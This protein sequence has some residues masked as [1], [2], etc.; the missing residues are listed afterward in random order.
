MPCG[1]WRMALLALAWLQVLQAAFLQVLDPWHHAWWTVGFLLALALLPRLSRP[2]AWLGLGLF[3]L[4]LTFSSGRGEHLR[5][6]ALWAFVFD[7]RWLPPVKPRAG[8]LLL[9]FDGECM[10]CNRAIRFLA[11]EDRA[12]LLRFVK[13]Q[14]KRG[15]ALEAVAGQGSLKTMLVQEDGRVL[16]RS[17]AALRVARALGG[18]WRLLA[19]LGSVAPRPLADALYDFIAAHR[20]QWFGKAADS[21]ELPTPELLSRLVDGDA[22]VDET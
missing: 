8:K 21:C 20:Y 13:L 17:S 3:I 16:D 18:H 14:S 15:A 4:A 11:T 2:W 22:E 7:P 9:A 19:I 10:V 1:L 12:D 6:L 5:M